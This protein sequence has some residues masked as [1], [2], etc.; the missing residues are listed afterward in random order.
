MITTTMTPAITIG[1]SLIVVKKLI[2]TIMMINM[3]NN[4]FVKM[5]GPITV[6]IVLTK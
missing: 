4:V 5:A 6:I 2:L 3:T 1:V